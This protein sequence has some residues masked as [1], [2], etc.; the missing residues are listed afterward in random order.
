MKYS[1]LNNKELLELQKKFRRGIIKEE[2]IPEDVVKD[3]EDLY[4]KQIQYLEDEIKKDKE[5]IIQIKRRQKNNKKW[6]SFSDIKML[7]WM[8]IVF[9]IIIIW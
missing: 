1:I 5:K 7:Y 8:H 3:L 9:E 4:K 6:F 2:D